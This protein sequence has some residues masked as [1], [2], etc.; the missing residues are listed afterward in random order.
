[1]EDIHYK[2][3]QRLDRKIRA[4]SISIPGYLPGIIPWAALCVLLIFETHCVNRNGAS[5]SK[6]AADKQKTTSSYNLS[7]T[8]YRGEIFTDK[9]RIEK[10]D[11]EW[12][13]ILSPAQYK[14]LR[15]N[16]TE[17]PFSGKYNR[18]KKRG[19]FVCA[20]CGL[21]LF[22]SEAKYDSGSGWPSFWSPIHPK[23]VGTKQDGSHGMIRTEIYCPR[24]GGHL[25]HV[26]KDGPRPTGLRYCVNSLSLK[27][28]VKK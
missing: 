15:Q 25:G 6:N 1:M 11:R 2:L 12:K 17:P 5:V 4:F 7:K 8:P 9:S 27:F 18:I 23:N 24:C 22:A 21:P 14:I 16:G 26:F 3:N 28:R 13:K 20:G 19:I 10:P